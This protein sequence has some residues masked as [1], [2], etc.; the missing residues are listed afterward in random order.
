MA[1]QHANQ[2]VQDR[3][4]AFIMAMANLG[5]TVT[6]EEIAQKRK[7]F[8]YEIAGDS[9]LAVTE[10]GDA[11]S[12]EDVQRILAEAPET[13][14]IVDD[15]VK[16]DT[17]ELLVN[18]PFW[19]N[20]W[21]FSEGDQGEYATLQIMASREIMTPTGPTRKLVLTD[22]STGIFQQ[23]RRITM[24]SGQQTRLIVRN[25]LRVSRYTVE[26]DEGEKNA[27]TFYLN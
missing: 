26:T 27:E 13:V 25:G 3:V 23:L 20:K 8:E 1:E 18:V 10:G 5:I 9:S 14:Q 12:W 22:G 11:E 24:A 15:Y 17:K 19:I 2:D 4:D 21:W 6:E 7:E 16:V